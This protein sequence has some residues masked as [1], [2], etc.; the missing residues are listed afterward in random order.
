ML[1]AAWIALNQFLLV[2][3]IAMGIFYFYIV[4]I[5]EKTPEKDTTTKQVDNTDKIAMLKAQIQAG[6]YQPDYDA[7]ADKMLSSEF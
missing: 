2:A 3:A 1:E 5:W 4:K 6:T 7:I